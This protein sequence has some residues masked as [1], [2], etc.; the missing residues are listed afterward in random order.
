MKWFFTLNEACA[1]YRSYGEMIMVAV[2]TAR[3]HTR[4][5]PHLLH[6]GGETWLTRWLRAEDVAVI[7]VRSRFY[8]M[9]AELA[10]ATKVPGVLP[11]GAGAFLRL[12]IPH[13]PLEDEFALYT[14]CDVMFTGDLAPLEA[15]RPPLFAAAPSSRP[16]DYNAMNSGVLLMNLP[17][18][19]ADAAAFEAAV[20][21]WLP[22]LVNSQGWDQEA[23]RRFY[24]R[25]LLR[26]P[27]WDRLPMEYN[28]K[29]Y[30]GV[31]PQARIVHF[32]GPKPYQRKAL[33][34]SRKLSQTVRRYD[35]PAFR[36]YCALWD[37]ERS[38]MPAST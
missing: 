3:R 17:A 31:N 9:L 4:L 20:Q 23:Y 5:Q 2:R 10:V 25:R 18:L 37:E 30:W 15:M 13:L 26:R 12:E 19:R 7:T 29:P 21:E 11:V 8:E 34:G 22:G 6:D 35:G 27:R 28:W 24:G 38:R 32:H 14:D 16:H 33:D 1:H 36:E